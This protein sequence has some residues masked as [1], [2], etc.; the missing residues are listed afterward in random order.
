M[1][2]ASMTDQARVEEAWARIASWLRR[3]APV[4]ASSVQSGATVG[5]I[6]AAEERMS[7]NLQ[8]AAAFHRQQRPEAVAR[9]ADT[10]TIPAPLKAW[11]MLVNGTGGELEW[12]DPA[13]DLFRR[14]WLPG[15]QTFVSVE[16]AASM[17]GR[18]MDNLLEYESYTGRWIPFAMFDPDGVAGLFVNATPSAATAGHVADWNLEDA[19]TPEGF[20]PPKWLEEI[21]AALE[22]GR[23]LELGDEL[24][25]SYRWPCLREGALRWL[26]LAGDRAE[27]E[28]EGWQPVNDP[29]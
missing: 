29:R 17:H 11:W 16:A 18:I 19:F 3:H 6:A 7:R 10:V 20:L 27:L 12:E 28:L 25:P 21:A 22:A 23:G 5:Q 4:A 13:E 15:W 14:S 24:P 9:L 26:D 1:G 2:T 8:A